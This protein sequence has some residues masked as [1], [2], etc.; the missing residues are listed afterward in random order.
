M[1]MGVGF[2]VSVK[3]RDDSLLECSV[4]ILKGLFVGIQKGGKISIVA[5]PHEFILSKLF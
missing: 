4:I 2:T 5:G 1:D 3:Y